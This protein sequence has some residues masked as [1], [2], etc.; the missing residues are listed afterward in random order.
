M[1]PI[2]NNVLVRKILFT[3]RRYGSLVLPD[4]GYIEDLDKPKL[5]IVLEVG[6]ECKEVKPLDKV[7]IQPGV[8]ME[9]KYQPDKGMMFDDEVWEALILS[10]DIIM[11][12]I[13]N[14]KPEDIG[15]S[16]VSADTSLQLKGD[17]KD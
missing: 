17:Y 7:I 4:T 1:K 16:M 2:R 10:E 12:V 6:P 13:D 5:A 15:D 11:C 3:E 8:G 9:M 14:L